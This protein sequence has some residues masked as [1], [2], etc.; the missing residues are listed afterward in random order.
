[1]TLL[2]MCSHQL[3]HCWPGCGCS[4]WTK[5]SNETTVETRNK[6]NWA[7]FINCSSFFNLYIEV[8]DVKHLEVGKDKWSVMYVFTLPF[9]K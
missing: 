2:C 7:Q 3:V 9:F 5:P 1:M 6:K 4:K 8:S